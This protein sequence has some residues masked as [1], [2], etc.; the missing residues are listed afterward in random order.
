MRNKRGAELSVNTIILIIIGVLILAFIIYGF[1]T[2]WGIFSGLFKKDNNVQDL[3]T[4]CD[5]VCNVYA[6]QFDYCLK[7]RTLTIDKKDT[8]RITCYWLE[9]KK[10]ELGFKTCIAIDCSNSGIYETA[11]IG[12]NGKNIGDKINFLNNTGIQ[13]EYACTVAD[14]AVA[15]S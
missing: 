7:E 10:A 1:A 8:P 2:G 14:G 9:N 6:S 15:A 11:N 13:R 5:S 4:D 12:C 3:N